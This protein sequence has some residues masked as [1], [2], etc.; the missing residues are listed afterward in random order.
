MWAMRR[1]NSSGGSN[2]T[3]PLHSQSLSSPSTWAG[4][5]PAEVKV[6]RAEVG[7]GGNWGKQR[8]RATIGP[9]AWLRNVGRVCWG[10]RAG[11][12]SSLDLAFLVPPAQ[13]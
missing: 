6:K 13:P 1:L 10:P 11:G 3:P 2:P 7:A 8:G 9:E 4:L 12:E 5:G